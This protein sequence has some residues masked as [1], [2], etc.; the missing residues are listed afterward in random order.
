VYLSQTFHDKKELIINEM[1][2]AANNFIMNNSKEVGNLNF[3]TQTIW[4]LLT[5]LKLKGLIE[6]RII[7]TGK[8]AKMR[9]I[10]V[11]KN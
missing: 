7:Q 11:S 9:Y 2:L 3:S 1:F 4:R 6:T 5:D 10:K 8:N